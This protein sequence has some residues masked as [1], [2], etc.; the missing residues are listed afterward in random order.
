MPARSAT[1]SNHAGPDGAESGGGA[2]A[3]PQLR[4]SVQATSAIAR[5]PVVIASAPVKSLLR[6][7]RLNQAAQIPVVPATNDSAVGK[8]QPAHAAK[9]YVTVGRRNAEAVAF[10]RRGDMPAH[11]DL[12]A[13]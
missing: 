9:R 11:G 3:R 4:V 12:C 6:R 1:F 10:V 2:G 13:V 7:Q 5:P 8:L